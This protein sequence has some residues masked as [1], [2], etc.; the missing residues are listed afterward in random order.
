MARE[1]GARRRCAEDVRERSKP[2][3]CLRNNHS[4]LLPFFLFI[5]DSSGVIVHYSKSEFW[6]SGEWLVYGRKT[7]FMTF[8]K[9]LHFLL[10]EPSRK[11]SDCHCDWRDHKYLLLEKQSGRR[12]CKYSGWPELI[13]GR[14]N[15]NTNLEKCVAEALTSQYNLD[16]MNA[17]YFL[18]KSVFVVVLF[19]FIQVPECSISFV[20]KLVLKHVWKL[21]KTRGKQTLDSCWF[22]YPGRGIKA[23]VTSSSHLK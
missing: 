21:I 10:E 1:S 23:L 22:Y 18:Q 4:W 12:S 7:A 5:P 9:M 19:F 6:M 17:L 15:N 14:H 13:K 2:R 3:S 11:Y 20:L 16:L 8:G